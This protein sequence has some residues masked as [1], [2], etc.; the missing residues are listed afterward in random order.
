VDVFHDTDEALRASWADDR[1]VLEREGC[2]VSVIRDRPS[3]VEA[4][5]GRGGDV[6]VFQWARDS[7]YRF[8]PLLTHPDFGLTLHPFDLA[9][10]K[11]LAL[12]GRVE[13]RDFVDTLACDRAVQ[14]L[15]YLAWA[16]CG[17]DPAFSP[18]AILEQAA[19]GARYSQAELSGLDFEAGPPDAAALSREWHGVLAAAREVVS[20]LPAEHAGCAVLAPDGSPVRGDPA[21]L[22]ELLADGQ[23]VFH[24][25]R[26][27]GALPVIVR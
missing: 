2:V 9:T 21:R 3:F 13:P 25:G 4:E 18:A 8:F 6:V 26:V 16:A 24:E 22:R 20:L 27:G 5:V 14:P 7:A 17:K 23:L 19:R 12:I 1:E 10:N 11:V 15:G